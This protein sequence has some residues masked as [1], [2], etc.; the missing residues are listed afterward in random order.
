ME[1]GTGCA[2]VW[3]WVRYCLCPLFGAGNFSEVLQHLEH[4]A[5]EGSC[6]DVT[7]MGRAVALEVVKCSVLFSFLLRILIPSC[8]SDVLY[9][10]K[11]CSYVELV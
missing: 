8:F 9:Y 4:A 6:E 2:V 5:S 7:Y 11:N 1:R 10:T 3:T